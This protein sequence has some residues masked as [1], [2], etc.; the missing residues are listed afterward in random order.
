MSQKDKDPRRTPDTE[1]SDAFL[2]QLRE[3]AATESAENLAAGGRIIESVFNDPVV[4]EV[5]ARQEDGAVP[6]DAHEILMKHQFSGAHDARTRWS[7]DD[8]TLTIEQETYGGKPFISTALLT[9]L[10]LVI[11]HREGVIAYNDDTQE[12]WSPVRT[13]WKVRVKLG[14]VTLRAEFWQQNSFAGTRQSTIDFF[15]MTETGS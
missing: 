5:L 9:D 8:K 2:R 10:V 11:L 4:R 3:K 15:L 12:S 7:I 14:P 6:P 1:P 13:D